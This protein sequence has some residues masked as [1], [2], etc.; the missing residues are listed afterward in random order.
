MRV[1]WSEPFTR[2]AAVFEQARVA[3][4][5]DPNAMTLATVDAQG[6]PSLRVVLLK[7]FDE[8]GFVFYTNH[9]SRKGREALST[10]AVALNFYWP[11]LDTQ[12]RVEGPAAPVSDAEADAYFATRP[13]ESQLGAWASLQSQALPSREALEA[14]LAEVTARYEGAPVPRPAH[15]S[16]FR[17]SPERLEFWRAH[18]HRLHWRDVYERVSDAWEKGLLYP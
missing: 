10:K 9:A 8:Q 2:F 17:V 15:W 12:V 7:D 4:P 6:R 1:P 13:R 5:K 14:R 18:P 11:S 16:G 3:H